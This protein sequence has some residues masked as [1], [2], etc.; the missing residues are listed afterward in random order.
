MGFYRIS[1]IETIFLFICVD[2][3]LRMLMQLYN[4]FGKEKNII[5][6]SLPVEQIQSHSSRESEPHWGA[7]PYFPRLLSLELLLDKVTCSWWQIHIFFVDK[8]VLCSVHSVSSIWSI[9]NCL[10]I[11]RIKL[12]AVYTSLC[13]PNNSNSPCFMQ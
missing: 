8:E 12:G 5:K 10:Q 9:A 6:S 2:F 1:K 7:E 4:I 3:C 13:H 11:I